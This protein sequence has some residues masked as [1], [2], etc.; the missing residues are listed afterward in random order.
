MT[1]CEKCFQG[2]KNVV[3]TNKALLITFIMVILPV[4]EYQVGFIL[5]LQPFKNFR[6]E[7]IRLMVRKKL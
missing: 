2:A 1:T 4:Y 3:V 6:P 5:N 7:K